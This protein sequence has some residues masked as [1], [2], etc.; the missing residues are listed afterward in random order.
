MTKRNQIKFRDFKRAVEKYIRKNFFDYNIVQKSGS[1]IRY[2][3]F[4][5][6]DK[7][8]SKMWVVHEDEHVHKGDLKK[9]CNNLGIEID[10]LIGLV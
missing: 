8:P 6:G 10:D 4:N 1:G 2:E 9:T 5:K 3:L 7:A